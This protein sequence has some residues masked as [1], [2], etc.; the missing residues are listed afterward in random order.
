M[1]LIIILIF[2]SLLT[3]LF[4]E[5][6]CLGTY[7]HALSQQQMRANHV[8]G[9]PFMKNDMSGLGNQKSPLGDNFGTGPSYNGRPSSPKTKQQ[10]QQ[11]QHHQQ[12]AK[13]AAAGIN[14]MNQLAQL[15][16]SS[17]GYGMGI[18]GV[19]PGYPSPIARPQVGVSK[20]RKLSLSRKKNS[21]ICKN[22]MNRFAC[23]IHVG[24]DP[25][26]NEDPDPTVEKYLDLVNYP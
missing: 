13:L 24:S 16:M 12:Q 26:E 3:S 10:Q 8:A 4:N 14:N 2:S 7:N 20:K 22:S 15:R 23:I 18:P 25:K 9:L 19:Q 11:Q 6:V 5:L 17:L 1:N 21:L